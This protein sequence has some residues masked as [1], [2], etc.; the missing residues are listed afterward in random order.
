MRVA[1]GSSAQSAAFW[2]GRHQ[3]DTQAARALDF[4]CYDPEL[5]LYRVWSA[6]A[7]S[8]VGASY[9]PNQA[10]AESLRRPAEKGHGFRYSGNTHGPNNLPA[11]H[12]EDELRRYMG[13]TPNVEFMWRPGKPLPRPEEELLSC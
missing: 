1:E 2:I 6:G 10:W 13:V 7:N 9:I 12:V 8:N 11:Q 4:D 5:K 3:A